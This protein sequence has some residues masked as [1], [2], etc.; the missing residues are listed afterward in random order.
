MGLD[1]IVSDHT[2]CEMNPNHRKSF[3]RGMYYTL[4]YVVAVISYAIMDIVNKLLKDK[5]LSVDRQTNRILIH[6]S[7]KAI[8]LSNIK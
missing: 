3:W 1:H 7:L 8:S 6:P 4:N 2:C 5:K